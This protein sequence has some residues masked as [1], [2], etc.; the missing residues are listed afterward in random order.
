VSEAPLSVDVHV[1]PMRRFVGA[2]GE[3]GDQPMWSPM[4]STLISGETDAILV[5]T[6]VAYEQVDKLAD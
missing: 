5:D 1:A 6:L 4:S 3:A 2:S